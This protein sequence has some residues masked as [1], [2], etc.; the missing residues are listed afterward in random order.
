M[1]FR[2]L[3]KFLF[4]VQENDKFD[5]S[6]LHEELNR[7]CRDYF[8]RIEVEKNDSEKGQSKNTGCNSMFETTQNID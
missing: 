5:R 2:S 1:L 8:K 4:W 6:H 7:E 3:K